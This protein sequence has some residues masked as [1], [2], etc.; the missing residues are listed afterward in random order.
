MHKFFHQTFVVCAF[1]FWHAR[2]RTWVM[3]RHDIRFRF[4]HRSFPQ[5]QPAILVGL[6][7]EVTR[8]T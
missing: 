3:R 1:F 7:V 5:M 8:P 2:F 4:R 6:Q